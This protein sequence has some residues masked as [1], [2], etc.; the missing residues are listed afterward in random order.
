[1]SGIIFGGLGLSPPDDPEPLAFNAWA[2]PS[3]DSAD[4]FTEESAYVAGGVVIHCAWTSNSL[5]CVSIG[6]YACEPAFGL[7]GLTLL[8]AMVDSR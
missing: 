8:L 7:I 6:A 3:L 4:E 5:G 1:M 2:E